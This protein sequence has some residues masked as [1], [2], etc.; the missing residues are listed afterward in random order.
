M[1]TPD[2]DADLPLPD[3][4]CGRYRPERLIPF[5][6]NKTY[7]VLEPSA[8]QLAQLQGTSAFAFH[9]TD[10]LPGLDLTFWA[11]RN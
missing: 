8:E 3:L 10:E 4:L 2:T 11:I 5:H 6:A 1:N 9:V 7:F